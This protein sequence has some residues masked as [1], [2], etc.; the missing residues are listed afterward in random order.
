MKI[1]EERF[2]FFGG[3]D[4]SNFL[5][6][7]G[8]KCIVIAPPF[9]KKV[10]EL[11]FEACCVKDILWSPKDYLDTTLED[12]EK[13][14]FT[15][16]FECLN[17]VDCYY[18]RMSGSQELFLCSPSM[19][20]ASYIDYWEDISINFIKNTN[21][22]DINLDLSDEISS[23][24]SFFRGNLDKSGFNEPLIEHYLKLCCD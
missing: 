1:V 24:I 8:Y 21:F 13:L 6:P 11:L 4:S 15:S 17:Q 2:S 7:N 16:F 3:H 18:D 5:R 20:L 14:D 23:S 22:Q 9:G 10:T 12:Q 19:A